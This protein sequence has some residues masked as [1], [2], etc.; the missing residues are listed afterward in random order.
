MKK[1]PDVKMK[2]EV[3]E[4]KHQRRKKGAAAKEER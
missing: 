3:I 2:S 4:L 1:M